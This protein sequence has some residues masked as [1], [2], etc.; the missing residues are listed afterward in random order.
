MRALAT[1]SLALLLAGCASASSRSGASTATL[2]EATMTTRGQL[3]LAGSGTAR[4]T[5]TDLRIEVV[6]DPNG[7]PDLA[8]LR[9]TGQGASEH[10]AAVE[11]WIRTSRFEPAE[12][13]GQRVTS[14][15]RTQIQTRI[16]VERVG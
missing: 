5:P 15:F 4:P 12:R 8:T 1:I 6:V 11:Q 13:G 14:V 7:Q 16:R 9:V 10:R 2:P 3:S